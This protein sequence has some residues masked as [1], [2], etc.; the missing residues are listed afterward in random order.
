MTRK[1]AAIATLIV[2]LISCSPATPEDEDLDEPEAVVPA[3]TVPPPTPT[4][5]SPPSVEPQRVDFT[6]EDGVNLA[7]YYHAAPVPNAPVVVLMHWARGDQKEWSNIG[8][9]DWLTHRSLDGFADEFPS[10]QYSVFTFDFRGF[11]ESGGQFDP[12]GW[13]MD[14]RAAYQTAQ[15]LPGVD[16]AKVVGVGSSI[17]ADAVVDA[18]GNICR[19]ALSLSPGGYLGIPYADAVT[20]LNAARPNRVNVYCVTSEGDNESAPACRSASGVSYQSMIFP[21][22]VHGTEFL[23]MDSMRSQ[24]VP[25]ISD[26]LSVVYAR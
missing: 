21:G 12:A 22:S 6:A 9:V 19:G 23:S 10:M 24:V 20:A 18:C 2:F 14:A 16:P 3:D 7:G 26:W 17:G 8:F 5:T 1:I 13:L 25:L 4:N 11:G 15:R